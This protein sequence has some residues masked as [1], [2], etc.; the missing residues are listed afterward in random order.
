MKINRAFTFT[1]LA[2][3]SLTSLVG[4]NKKINYQNYADIFT[5]VGGTG[6][7]KNNYFI[8]TQF[9]SN[10]YYYDADNY[11]LNEMKKLTPVKKFTKTNIAEK[12]FVYTLYHNS[13]DGNA[14]WYGYHVS[15]MSFYMNGSIIVN[16]YGSDVRDC[17]NYFTLSKEDTDNFFK[18]V[19]DKFQSNIDVILEDKETTKNEKGIDQLLEYLETKQEVVGE[20]YSK[21][22]SY[23]KADTFHD[24]GSVLD[25]LKNVDFKYLT[26]EVFEYNY[27]VEN[28]CLAYNYSK[29]KEP[30]ENEKWFLTMEDNL[31]YVTVYNRIGLD[32]TGNPETCYANHYT[33]SYEAGRAIYQQA[34]NLL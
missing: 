27:I 32:R 29:S 9:G 26:T 21:N 30:E 16:D 4:C 33:I 31:R 25:T 10:V 15:T 1:L 11:M 2:V 20:I 19:E 8:E 24:E 5:N 3:A 14:E 23:G 13:Q 18:V 12:R 17:Y 7:L 22:N 28:S 34:V 6:D